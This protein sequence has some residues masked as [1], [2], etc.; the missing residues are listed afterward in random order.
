MRVL[1][2]D[3]ESRLLLV[4]GRDLSDGSDT[5]RWWFTAGGGVD[6]G[7]SLIEAAQRELREE[8]G[9]AGVHLV[10]PFHRREVD[11]LNHGEPQHQVEHFF[12]ARAERTT[13]TMDEWTELKLQAVTRWR[14]WSVADLE[15]SEVQFFP[16]NLIELM[17]RARELV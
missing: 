12:A 15:T 11:F 2:F 16:E 5:E 13:L 8:T 3:R 7:E 4:E 6:D 17:R 14:W 9:M 1:L 10:G